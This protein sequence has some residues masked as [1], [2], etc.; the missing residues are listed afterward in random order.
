MGLGKN[1]RVHRLEIKGNDIQNTLAQ[2][3]SSLD[4]EVV[5]FIPKIRKG[6]LP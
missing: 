4:G 5:S 6:S 1:Y 2:F 3:I